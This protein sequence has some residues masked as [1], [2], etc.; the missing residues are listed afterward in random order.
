[1][2][3]DR[4]DES[5]SG[6]STCPSRRAGRC[7]GW[8][9]PTPAAHRRRA[10]VSEQASDFSANDVLQHLAVER[11]VGDELAQLDVLV[12]EL[13]QPPHLRRRQPLVLLLPIEVGRLADPGLPADLRHGCSLLALLQDERL[14]GVAELRS[15]H[16]PCSFPAW[17]RNPKTLTPNAPVFRDQTSASG[18]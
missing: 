12:L 4:A 5:G 14:L 3:P 17:V 7:A 18:S 8:T 15:L 2:G 13:L 16:R 6:R 11:E 1:M 10:R 9:S